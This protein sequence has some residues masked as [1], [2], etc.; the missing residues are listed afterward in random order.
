MARHEHLK[1]REDVLLFVR[2]GSRTACQFLSPGKAGDPFGQADKSLLGEVAL[3]ARSQCECNESASFA[4]SHKRAA[5]S[6]LGRLDAERELV[7]GE[8]ARH[9]TARGGQVEEWLIWL[10]TIGHTLI[11]VSAANYQCWDSRSGRLGTRAAGQWSRRLARD[12]G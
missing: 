2:T 8:R 9:R 3:R 6:A 5:V 7:E 4:R 1:R 12:G 11:V 10:R